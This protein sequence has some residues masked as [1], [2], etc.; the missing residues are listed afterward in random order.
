ME[1]IL[2]NHGNIVTTVEYNVPVVDYPH[3]RAI[4]Y[5]E[6]AASDDVY[7]TILTFSTIEHSGLSRYGDEL[8]PESDLKTFGGFGTIGMGRTCRT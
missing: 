4:S 5:D 2:L 7:D 8:D 6:F 1:A 3:L